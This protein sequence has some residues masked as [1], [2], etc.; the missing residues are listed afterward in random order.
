MQEPAKGNDVV[1]AATD[2]G[3][4]PPLRY[5]LLALVVG[6]VAGLGAVVFRGL[7]AGFHNALFLGRFSLEYDANVHTPLSP[8]GPLVVLVPVLGAVGVAFL[9]K[10]FAPEA[11]GHGV[12]EVMDAIYYGG[13]KIRPVVA[14]VKSLAS[15]LSI[16]SGGSVGREGPI[17]Q[18]GSSFGSTVGQILRLPPWQR[19]TLIAGGAGAGIAATFNTPVGGVLFALEIMMHEVSAR[20]LVPVAIC[21]ATAT[22]IGRLFFGPHP[23]FLIPELE[24]PYFHVSSPGLLVAYVPLAILVGL[25]SAA[26]IRSIY[27][28][29]DFFTQKVKG[30]YYV[31]HMAGMLAVGVIMYVLMVCFGHY[32]IEGVGY[33]TVQDILSGTESNRALL[34]LLLALKLLATSLTLGSGASGGIFSPA[35]FLGATVGGAY[36]VL[37]QRL[38]PGMAISPPAFAVAGMAGMVG[39]S[40]GAAL[41]AIVM[42]FE[43]TLD[44]RVIIPMT[45][46]VAISYGVRKVVCP[47]SIYTLKLVR[48]GHYMP[49]ALQANAHFLKRASELMDAHFLPIPSSTPLDEVAALLEND[50]TTAFGLVLDGNRVKGILTRD[51]AQGMV[52]Q[53]GKSVAVGEVPLIPFV[54]VPVSA[55]LV[56]IVEAL[57]ANRASVALVSNEPHE[58]SPVHIQGVVD[59]TRILDS[60]A[61]ALQLYYARPRVASGGRRPRKPV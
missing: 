2:R 26:F 40:T 60:V 31:Q 37:L 41:A 48:R 57:H 16:G 35:L 6:I 9:V 23:S 38:F 51:R 44:Y 13:G 32:Y 58:A 34:L 7:I 21:T 30:G 17:I 39:G 46:T 33:A 24:Q 3:S 47:E 42:I 53:N 22:Y 45:I 36:G 5:S 56:D 1:A 15:A 10:N 54:I 52:R 28:F 19:I 25:L 29:E 43:M 8:W 4:L 27:A 12:P 11:K 18:I 14:L 59:K 55:S 49:D 61:D 20:T 50:D